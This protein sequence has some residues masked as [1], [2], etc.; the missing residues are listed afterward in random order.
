MATVSENLN[1][2]IDIKEDLKDSIINKGGAM[3]DSVPF[4]DYAYEIDNIPD[5]M[6]LLAT[7]MLY[8]YKLPNLISTL[9]KCA[10]AFCNNITSVGLERN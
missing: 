6:K 5:N 9:R 1:K 10:F 3:G 8:E 4:R 2:L 7:G